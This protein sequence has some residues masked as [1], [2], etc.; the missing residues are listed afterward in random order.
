MSNN[1]SGGG[2]IG[3]GG[4]VFV[5]FLTLKLAGVID[6][7]WWWVF[8]PLLLPF[9]IVAVVWLFLGVVGSVAWAGW[10]LGGK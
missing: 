1:S 4:V 5:V 3:I 8:S 7:S 10:K 9:A 6:W 2:G